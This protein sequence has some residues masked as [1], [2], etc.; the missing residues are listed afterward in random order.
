[1]VSVSLLAYAGAQFLEHA[2]RSALLAIGVTVG[3]QDADATDEALETK[4]FTI[5]EAVGGR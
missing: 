1:M 2:G 5:W 3:G 4:L